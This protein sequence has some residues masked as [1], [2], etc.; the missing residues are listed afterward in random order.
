MRLR[1]GDR[2]VLYTDGLPESKNASGEE[3][4]IPRCLKIL[5]THSTLSAGAIAD[6]IL[7]EISSWSAAKKGS[8]RQQDDDMT[9]I[10]L[11]CQE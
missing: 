8:D 5:N 4:G 2:Y 6:R 11:D 3:F 1:A 9:L 10:V 7:N